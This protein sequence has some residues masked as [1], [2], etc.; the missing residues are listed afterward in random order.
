MKAI[1]FRMMPEFN[2]SPDRAGRCIAVTV[3]GFPVRHGFFAVQSL[4][5]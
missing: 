1:G 4:L 3:Y 2:L 5:R